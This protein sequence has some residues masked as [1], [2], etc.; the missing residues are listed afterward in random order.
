MDASS[1]NNEQRLPD[2]NVLNKNTHIEV[3]EDVSSNT[4]TAA[5]ADV[6]LAMVKDGRYL[7]SLVHLLSQTVSPWLVPYRSQNRHMYIDNASNINIL[8]P[9]L[10]LIAGMIHFLLTVLPIGRTL[11]MEYVGIDFDSENKNVQNRVGRDNDNTQ[12][13]TARKNDLSQNKVRKRHANKSQSDSSYSAFLTKF[14]GSRANMI[15]FSFVYVFAP[16]LIRRAGRRG[17]IQLQQLYNSFSQRRQGNNVLGQETGSQRNENLR[18]IDRRRVYEEQRRAMLA[19]IEAMEN[20]Q[21]QPQQ[22]QQQITTTN[23]ESNHA[24]VPSNNEATYDWNSFFNENI[25]SILTTA[26]RMIWSL[27]QVRIKS[28][29]TELLYRNLF[30]H[31]FIPHNFTCIFIFTDTIDN[32]KRTPQ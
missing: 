20:Q 24:H 3:H 18:G 21:R 22:P 17:W 13:N 29:I 16:Y 7:S 27:L 6:L 23:Q 26:R 14:G 32:R 19:R 5:I 12:Q 28:F 2:T 15:A 1:M 10:E 8:R 9:E 30:K 4:S 31:K 25:R 11:G